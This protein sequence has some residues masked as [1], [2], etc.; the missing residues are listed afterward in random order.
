M[1][2]YELGEVASFCGGTPPAAARSS[3][4]AGLIRVTM[5]SGPQW[6][7]SAISRLVPAVL[8]VLTK[9]NRWRCEA[10]TEQ[11]PRSVVLVGEV[12]A[13]R[14]GARRPRQLLGG[15]YHD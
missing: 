9:T 5:S 13:V 8:R 10:I 4:S 1:W 2:A 6:R 15:T 11:D 7:D 14:A 3:S 12:L